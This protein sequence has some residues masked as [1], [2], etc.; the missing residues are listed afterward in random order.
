M[1]FQ[2]I[3]FSTTFI[4]LTIDPSLLVIHNQKLVVQKK[5]TH[6]PT[7]YYIVLHMTKQ[8]S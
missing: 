6:K 5:L 4:E 3:L 2:S 7:N 1:S 8:A